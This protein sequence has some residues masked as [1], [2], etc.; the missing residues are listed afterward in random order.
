MYPIPESTVAWPILY[1]VCSN[2][3]Q[4]GRLDDV[5]AAGAV[6]IPCAIV[7]QRTREHMLTKLFFFMV[8]SLF[9]RSLVC[10]ACPIWLFNT[11]DKYMASDVERISCSA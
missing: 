2:D 6:R 9:C 1:T 8:K 3:R 5:L 4:E 11:I 10:S 7:K